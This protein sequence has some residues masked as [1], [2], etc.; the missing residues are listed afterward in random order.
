M[1]KRIQ[2][3]RRPTR[4]AHPDN[5]GGCVVCL[6][7]TANGVVNDKR[8]ASPGRTSPIATAF[9]FACKKGPFGANGR[10]ALC[11]EGEVHPALHLFAVALATPIY[12]LTLFPYPM[13]CD[14]TCWGARICFN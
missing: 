1:P 10:G 12:D 6:A 14:D 7:K 2:Q 9:H 4:E 11:A 3:G 5:F 13:R 8:N